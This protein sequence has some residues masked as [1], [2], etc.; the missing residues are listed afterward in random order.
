MG[1][2][3]DARPE[4]EADDSLVDEHAETVE[5]LAAAPAGLGNEAGG[6]GIRDDVGDDEVGAK[7]VDIE[8]EA[9]VHVGEKADGGAVNKDVDVGGYLIVAVPGEIFG[10]GAGGCDEVGEG[11]AAVRRVIFRRAIDDGEV[12]GPGECEF[13]ADGAGGAAGAEEDDALALRFGERA[14]GGEEAFAV[15]VFAEEFVA[16]AS[17]AVDGADFLGGVGEA[18]EERDDGDLMRDGA[19]G[20]A[21]VHRAHAGDG[22][23]EVVGGDFEGEIAPGEVVVAIGGLDHRLGGVFGDG[24]AEDGGDLLFE[25][26]GHGEVVFGSIVEW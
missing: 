3:V 2:G 7:C 1:V 26:G 10:F 20:A 25:I 13:D 24:L 6:R 9:G 5:D 16:L 14:E 21:E 23:G 17:D 18:I 15:G 11:A 12:G 8:R 19:V 22:G 4:A